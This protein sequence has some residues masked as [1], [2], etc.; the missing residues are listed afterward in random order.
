MSTTI[1]DL[2]MTSAGEYMKQ[3][4]SIPKDSPSGKTYL[5]IQ[6]MIAEGHRPRVIACTLEVPINWVYDVL[7]EFEDNGFEYDF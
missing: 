2:K 3:V 6:E 1:R 4:Y 7:E 5:E